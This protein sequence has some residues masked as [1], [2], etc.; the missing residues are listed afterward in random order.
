MWHY[1]CLSLLCCFAL[2]C[3]VAYFLYV[4]FELGSLS[5]F[6][7]FIESIFKGQIKSM[8]EKAVKDSVA[9]QIPQLNAYLQ[10]LPTTYSIDMW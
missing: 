10:S 5:W 3:L 8:C 2:F 1:A 9:Q 7:N 4:W 6:Y